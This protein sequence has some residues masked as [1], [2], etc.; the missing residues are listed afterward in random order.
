MKINEVMGKT[1]GLTRKAICNLHTESA[2][3]A[4]IPIANE[5][6]G[7]TM[8]INDRLD[9]NRFYDVFVQNMAVLTTAATRKR[10]DGCSKELSFS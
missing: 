4:D 7:I 3:F 6:F 5:Q 1:T 10:C 2:T 9:R 8:E